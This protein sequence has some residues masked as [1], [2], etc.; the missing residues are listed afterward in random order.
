MRPSQAALANS[1]DQ[2]IILTPATSISSSSSCLS[3]AALYLSRLFSPPPSIPPPSLGFLL[4][5]TLILFFSCAT[6][7][8]SIV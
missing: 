5:G 1:R 3:P 7:S 2:A 4:R 8:L 6:L